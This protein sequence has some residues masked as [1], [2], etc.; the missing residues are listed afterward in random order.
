VPYR[1]ITIITYAYCIAAG[2]M[3]TLTG[4]LRPPVHLFAIS[5]AEAAAVAY[6][7][8]GIAVVATS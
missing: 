4:I 3:A 1:T 2:C 8:Y 7:L 6:V 5:G